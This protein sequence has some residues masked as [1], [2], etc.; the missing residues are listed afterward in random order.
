[1][2]TS[3]HNVTG[4]PTAIPGIGSGV[5]LATNVGG[6]PMRHRWQPSSSAAPDPES[7]YGMPIYVQD[8]VALVGRSN[9]SC[10]VWMVNAGETGQL[11]IDEVP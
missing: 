3:E 10:W 4:T 5:F 7:A 6:G 2:A 9:E 11:V 8:Q 1:M